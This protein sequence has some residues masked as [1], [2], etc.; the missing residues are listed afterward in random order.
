M[1]PVCENSLGIDDVA[2]DLLNGPCVGGMQY[3]RM[4]LGHGCKELSKLFDL[5]RSVRKEIAL[6]Y[7]LNVCVVEFKVL[8]LF[9]SM[10]VSRDIHIGF[11]G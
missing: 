3:I 5:R 8:R 1:K 2:N 10:I 9:W 4:Q 7:M 6:G 11:G